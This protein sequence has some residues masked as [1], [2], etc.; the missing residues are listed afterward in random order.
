MAKW[1]FA[2]CYWFVPMKHRGL[3]RWRQRKTSPL[4]APR[5]AKW[6]WWFSRDHWQQPLTIHVC[7]SSRIAAQ[8]V[9]DLEYTIRVTDNWVWHF[10][11]DLRPDTTA[12]GSRVW[13]GWRIIL[14][15]E[16]L[17][18]LMLR[19]IRHRNSIQITIGGSG[20]SVVDTDATCTTSGNRQRRRSFLYWYAGRIFI[21]NLRNVVASL[22]I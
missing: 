6:A 11:D 20:V 3:P 4:F 2:T 22:G 21:S 8:V 9:E 7:L 16:K 18:D 19:Q 10:P 12:T 5:M 1:S 17:Q 13:H 14:R 15:E